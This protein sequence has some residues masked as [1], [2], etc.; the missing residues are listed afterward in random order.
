MTTLPRLPG[1]ALPR[2][3]GHPRTIVY[4]SGRGRIQFQRDSVPGGME[5]FLVPFAPEY[6]EFHRLWPRSPESAV[7]TTI[8]I[9]RL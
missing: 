5:D 6:R 1:P 9:N 8:I 3:R 7:K 2:S 4:D